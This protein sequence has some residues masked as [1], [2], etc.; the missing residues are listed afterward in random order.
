LKGSFQDSA[1]GRKKEKGKEAN[2]LFVLV[3]KE[4][5]GAEGAPGLDFD[6]RK[7]GNFRWCHGN[8]GTIGKKAGQAL[9]K[10]KDLIC[11]ETGGPE[12]VNSEF[13]HS[14]LSTGEKERKGRI[15]IFLLSGWK[16]M[17]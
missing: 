7:E 12:R 5:E 15:C 2:Q 6:S 14:R 8:G 11:R 3:Y 4:E 9:V 10:K 16:V 13:P 17:V 1:R